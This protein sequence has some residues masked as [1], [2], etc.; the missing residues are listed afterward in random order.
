MTAKRM[1]I[2]IHDSMRLRTKAQLAV[3]SMVRANNPDPSTFVFGSSMVRLIHVN[4]DGTERTVLERLSAYQLKHHLERVGD[5]FMEVLTKEGPKEVVI[6]PPANVVHDLLAS[7]SWP[8]PP[9]E[10]IVTAPTFAP[11]GSLV[12]TR[13]SP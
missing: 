10:R 13:L 9:I 2:V 12:A 4:A 8:L 6:D 1:K 5:W 3:A 11:D 7:P